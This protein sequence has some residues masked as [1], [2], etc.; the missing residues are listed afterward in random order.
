M[1]QT[2]IQAIEAHF[3]WDYCEHNNVRRFCPTCKYDVP[4]F[5]RKGKRPIREIFWTEQTNNNLVKWIEKR[6]KL[7]R[8]MTIHDPEAVFISICSGALADTAGKRL[9]QKGVGE[10]LRRYANKAGIS[11]VNAHAFRHHMGH[12][13]VNKGGSA[14]DV[15]NILG[16]SSLASSSIY[17][18]M[19]DKELEQRYRMLKGD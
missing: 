5:V 10:M 11:Y 13:I 15:M 4:A 19:A 6:D 16:H 17:T 12:H 14:S 2:H 9:T 8:K 1:D 18:M 7:K 3:G